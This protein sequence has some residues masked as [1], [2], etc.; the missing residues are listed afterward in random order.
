MTKRNLMNCVSA[1]ALA[2]VAMSLA[3]PAMAQ[4]KPAENEA[5]ETEAIVV[6][7]SSS[8]RTAQNSSISV[9]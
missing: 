2:V 3:A 9:S 1:G 7:A 5:P 8:G 4:D 6:T